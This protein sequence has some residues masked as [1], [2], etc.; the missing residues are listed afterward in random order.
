MTL[1]NLTPSRGD[2]NADIGVIGHKNSVHVL[3]RHPLRMG[4][5]RIAV[6]SWTP[7]PILRVGEMKEFASTVDRKEK[8]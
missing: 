8:W 7:W 1:G 5:N 2:S 6:A 3:I 4:M